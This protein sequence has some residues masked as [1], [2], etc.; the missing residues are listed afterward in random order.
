MGGDARIVVLMASVVVGDMFYLPSFPICK[1]IDESFSV[2][3]TKFPSDITDSVR[4]YGLGA[5]EPRQGRK[6]ATAA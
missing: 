5:S 4:D 1:S 3:D 2:A 6:A